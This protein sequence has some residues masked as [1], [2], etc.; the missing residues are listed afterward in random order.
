MKNHS[1]LLRTLAAV[2][3]GILALTVALSGCAS[4]ASSAVGA[5]GSGSADGP[6]PTTSP[7]SAA[8]MASAEHDPVAA[9]ARG[10][11]DS[12][13]DPAGPAGPDLEQQGIVPVRVQI[14]AIGV[15]SGLEL[16][17]RDTAGSIQPPANFASAGWYHE[18]VVPGDVGPAVIA[19]H[20]DDAVGPAVFYDLSS[21]KAGDRVTVT[22]SDGATRI[23]AVDREIE[24]AKAAF[25]T[26]EVYGP[27][28]TA[29]LRLITCGGVF[30][31]S[32]G[33]YVDNV[34]VFAS[35]MPA[36]PGP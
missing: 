34:I 5:S 13:Q 30:D 24:V 3:G 26:G 23:F 17:S 31:D 28:P 27:T 36:S 20:I 19:G 21:L 25:P 10:A 32:I 18:G 4:D 33:H 1:A 7:A 2:G 29:Q 14:T 6:A 15:D 22:L 9:A 35:E 12:N 16:L 8:P 11:L